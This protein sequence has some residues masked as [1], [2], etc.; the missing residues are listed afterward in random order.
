[1]NQLEWDFIQARA[2]SLDIDSLGWTD[3]EFS[4]LDAILDHRR[5]IKA[6]AALGIRCNSEEKNRIPAMTDLEIFEIF[7]SCNKLPLRFTVLCA[8]ET[9]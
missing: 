3:L 4:C 5:G 6:T 8:D 1:L 9:A 2:G 7:V